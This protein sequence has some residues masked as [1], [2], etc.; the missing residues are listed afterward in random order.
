MEL[1]PVQLFWLLVLLYFLAVNLAA[2]FLYGLDKR[3]ARKDAWRISEKTLL[4]TALLGGS[5]GALAGMRLFRHKT[6]KWYFRWGVPAILALQLTA[7]A[8]AAAFAAGWR[9]WGP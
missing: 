1:T 2:L 9:P 6:R 5:V 3:R 7:L 4:L 8:L